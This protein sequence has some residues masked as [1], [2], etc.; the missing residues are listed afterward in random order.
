V[1][2]SGSAGKADA[3]SLLP[4]EGSGIR[5]GRNPY[6]SGAMIVSHRPLHAC[7]LLGGPHPEEVVLGGPKLDRGHSVEPIRPHIH[8]RC[9][10]REGA[11][12]PLRGG[13][14]LGQPQTCTECPCLGL[15]RCLEDQYFVFL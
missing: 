15:W 9:N 6:F 2:S 12:P 5:F 4:I 7:V 10:F 14:G 13:A 3:P 8:P 1:R 11:R